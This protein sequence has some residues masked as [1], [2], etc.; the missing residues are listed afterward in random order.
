MAFG[1]ESM[2]AWKSHRECIIYGAERMAAWQSHR[3]YIIYGAESIAAWQ[4][5]REY[6][7]Y[8]AESYSERRRES[9][10]YEWKKSPKGKC[11][12]AGR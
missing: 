5:H 1:A 9:V 6:I 3:E 8:E 4:S 2:A 12:G 10:K 7:I 11:T